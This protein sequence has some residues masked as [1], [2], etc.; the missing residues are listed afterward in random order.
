[1]YFVINRQKYDVSKG[2][3]LR[4]HE[5]CRTSLKHTKDDQQDGIGSEPHSAENTVNPS[6]PNINYH[7]R[8]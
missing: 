1:M 5:P 7:L 8:P 2:E 4:E 6:A 3:H